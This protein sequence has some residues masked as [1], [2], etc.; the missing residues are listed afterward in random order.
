M[1]PGSAGV[2]ARAGR[3]CLCLVA[4]ESVGEFEVLEGVVHRAS[5]GRGWGCAERLRCAGHGPVNC[6]HRP[7][8]DD[9]RASGGPPT[10]PCYRPGAS[11]LEPCLT[12]V[13]VCWRSGLV[14]ALAWR[15][16]ARDEFS[17]V[18][19][20]RGLDGRASAH[21]G[22]PAAGEA[23]GVSVV[24]REPGGFRRCGDRRCLGRRARRGGQAPADGGV[25]ACGKRLAPLDGRTVVRGCGRSAAAICS[26]S[27]RASSTPRCSP[28]GCADG[29]RALEDGDPV[30]ARELLAERW[31]CGAARRWPR[32]RLRISPRPRSA[33]SRSFG[34][35]RWRRRIE[36]DLQLGRH[37]ELIAELE[38]LLAEQ[39]T[40]ERLAASS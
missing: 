10:R 1:D 35:W 21:A 18:G 40:R 29:R 5:F 4:G 25:A 9:E 3:A 23:A 13:P 14:V 17:R 26:R 12:E 39:P 38:G 24:E 36:A 15:V 30:R 31:R 32:S 28:S 7:V 33:G 2:D 37:A 6:G 34:W 22:R 11:S 8:T 16:W 27:G 20:G 19:A